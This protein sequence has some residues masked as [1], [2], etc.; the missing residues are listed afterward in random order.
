MMINN[1][2]S[3]QT[4]VESRYISMFVLKQIS[5]KTILEKSQIVDYL[6]G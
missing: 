1:S 4:V 6:Y 5:K 2:K 3:G